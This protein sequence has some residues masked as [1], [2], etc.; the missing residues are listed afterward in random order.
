MTAEELLQSLFTVVPVFLIKI[1]SVILLGIHTLFAIILL[2]QV[3]LMTRVVM[4]K[5]SGIIFTIG[6]IHLLA[7]IFVLLWAILFL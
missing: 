1:F 5:N 7:S 3:R 2:R 6:V 4:A